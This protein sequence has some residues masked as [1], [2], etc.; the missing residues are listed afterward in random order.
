MIIFD[1]F[2]L[3][4]SAVASASSWEL[5]IYFFNQYFRLLAE[6]NTNFFIIVKSDGSQSFFKRFKQIES[7]GD[8]GK[9][10]L[11]E[12]WSMCYNQ[13]I[14]MRTI[15]VMNKNDKINR[16]F[17]TFWVKREYFSKSVFNT[18][19]VRLCRISPPLMGT[20]RILVW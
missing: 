1:I 20:A 9:I 3:E 5:Y 10:F 19:L 2:S 8:A 4:P 14:S 17:M 13:L 7:Y 11:N 18:W 12:S 6:S 16:L 15:V